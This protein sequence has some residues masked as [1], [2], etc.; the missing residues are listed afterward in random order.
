MSKQNKNCQYPQYSFPYYVCSTLNVI[1]RV[2]CSFFL[3][4]FLS[5]SLSS[6]CF[7]VQIW[8]VAFVKERN[9]GICGRRED[10]WE[11]SLVI[12]SIPLLL[13]YIV[14]YPTS[15]LL[16]PLCF[17]L[18]L[19]MYYGCWHVPHAWLHLLLSWRVC[20]LITIA[21]EG[22]VPRPRGHRTRPSVAKQQSSDSDWISL[23]RVECQMRL[24]LSSAIVE[25]FWGIGGQKFEM[26][27]SWV[28]M[29]DRK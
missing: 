4:I 24:R 20:G 23:A 13:G 10:L 19:W 14:A 21:Y 3:R 7:A 17:F 26:L 18:F 29:I 11:R 12:V 8:S 27:P 28:L 15:W 2:F 25:L 5:L 1:F 16:F 22:V 6:P 9:R